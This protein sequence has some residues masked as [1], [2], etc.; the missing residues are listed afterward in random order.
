M[1]WLAIQLY[2]VY[3]LG[4]IIVF[5]VFWILILLTI[6]AYFTLPRAIKQ[7]KCKHERVFETRACDAI[8]SECNKNL[9]FMGAW[10]AKQKFDAF[11]ERNGI[12]KQ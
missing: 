12:N 3:I 5:F 8:C 2:V 7:Y 10:A 1:I 9:G 11:N 6:W 4:L